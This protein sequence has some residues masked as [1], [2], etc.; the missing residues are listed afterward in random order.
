MPR[1]NK[2]RDEF[3][4][5][6]EEEEEEEVE[7]VEDEDEEQEEEQDQDDDM[8]EV[9]IDEM[10]VRNESEEEEEEREDVWKNGPH[11]VDQEV[12][13][14]KCYIHS[15]SKEGVGRFIK[16]T[17]LKITWE[18]V[19]EGEEHTIAVYHSQ[20]S[21]KKVVL[22]D[23]DTEYEEEEFFDAGLDFTFPFRIEGREVSVIISDALGDGKVGWNY[24]IL[25]D[26][27]SLNELNEERSMGAGGTYEEDAELF[28]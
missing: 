13:P 3:D 11:P 2:D 22:L 1:P 20:L 10:G 14:E 24:D 8:E 15:F 25:I 4:D 9:D 5:D 26:G 19:I 27:V 7:E 28:D 21:G 18:L 23:G 12:D 17:K 6:E 16:K